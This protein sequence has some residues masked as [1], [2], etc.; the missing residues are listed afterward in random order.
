MATKCH[1]GTLLRL[2]GNAFVC[3]ICLSSLLPACSQ[4]A[5]L[6]NSA[7]S[8]ESARHLLDAKEFSQA[9]EAL[10]VYLDKNPSSA[11]AHFLLGYTLFREKRAKES[12]AAFTE[13]AKFQRPAASD[14]KIVAADYVMLG[15]FPDADKWLTAVTQETP[16]DAEAW[17]L[18]GRTK[19]NENRFEE[20]IQCFKQ[21]LA[22]QANDVR[23][24][25]N[26]G[27]SYQGLNKLD[28]AKTVFETAIAWQKDAP[29]KD[30][31]PYLNLG[32]LLADQDNLQQALV[33]LQE[34]TA[35]APHNPKAHEELGRVYDL[36]KM[37]E[38]AQ[39]ELEQAVAL[40]PDAGGLHFKLGQIYRREG[41]QELAQ[42]Q[43]DI[44]AKLNSTHS[45]TETPNPAEQN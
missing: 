1:Y 19:Y 26:L 3:V 21:V 32:S 36:L 16:K 34:A 43:F 9:E 7:G 38:K 22:L 18:L 17:Y 27:L 40:A 28:E 24:E 14:L 23:A 8:L 31:Q 15:D 10:R 6:A 11:D 4:Q 35:L 29:V 25:D 45:S 42:Q 13:G 20:A 2:A 44:C 41:K 37:P 39:Q 5:G 12:L 33:Y 30:A